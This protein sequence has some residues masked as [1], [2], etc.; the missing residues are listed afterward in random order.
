SPLTSSPS[1][2]EG[3]EVGGGPRPAA[4][5]CHRPRPWG[6]SPAPGERV[7]WR[8]SLWSPE[9][10]YERHGVR[11]FNLAHCGARPRALCGRFDVNQGT[12]SAMPAGRVTE[13]DLY[14]TRE[15]QPNANE[16]A[17]GVPIA[18]DQRK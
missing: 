2:G 16:A 17:A 9:R 14:F 4:F 12:R 15:V 3:I 7:P 5:R 1:R 13:H 10:R 11:T 18:R 8:M 6:R